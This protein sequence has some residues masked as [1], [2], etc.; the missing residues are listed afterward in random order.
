MD[1]D[2]AGPTQKKQKWQKHPRNTPDNNQSTSHQYQTEI[3]R[4]AYFRKGARRHNVSNLLRPLM[5]MV[6][7]FMTIKVK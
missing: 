6:M 4:M 1:D 7:K 5:G 2:Q 3:H